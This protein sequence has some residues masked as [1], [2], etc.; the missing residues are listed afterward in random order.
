MLNIA[1][2]FQ[3]HQ[4]FRLRNYLFFDIG[5]KHNY[6]DK[7]LNRDI[8]QRVVTNSY[9]PANRM[10]QK[11][12]KQYGDKVKIN[13]ILSGTLLDQLEVHAPKTIDSFQR[14]IKTGQVELLGT[15]YSH[16][17]SFLQNEEVFLTELES[18]EIKVKELFGIKPK[19]FSNGCLTYSDNIAGILDAVGYLGVLTDSADAV[20]NGATINQV[21]RSARSPAVKLL[22]RHRHLSDDISLRFSNQSWDQWPL[23]AEKYMDWIKKL[24][25]TDRVLNLWMDYGAIGEHQKED[26]G[27][28]GFMEKLFSNMAADKKI[29]LSKAT[30]LLALRKR[31]KPLS[32]DAPLSCTGDLTMSSWR[33]NDMQK[34][35]FET[36]Y[37]LYPKI[38]MVT[39][40]AILRDWYY[41]QSSDHFYYMGTN[42]D[43]QHTQFSPYALPYEACIN[44]MNVLSDFRLRVEE[45]L[46]SH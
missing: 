18:Y 43:D 20:L 40:Q 10:F 15:T 32:I 35:A 9:M 21:Y 31:P 4:P 13:L 12:I 5:K 1:F 3:A 45:Y 41:L 28:F 2:Y 34:E 29:N 39:D 7:S 42:A 36:L 30:E 26:T 6:Y 11:L 37:S 33:E 38:A 8:I 24:N 17:L 46:R 16:S 44:Y 23:S 19:V 14:L 22:F 27:I 25:K